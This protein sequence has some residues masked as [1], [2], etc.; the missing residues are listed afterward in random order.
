MNIVMMTNTYK[1][2]LGGL[3]RSVETVTAELR[4][5][6]HEVVIVMPEIEKG[7]PAP[8]PQVFR[9]P[10]L[11][12]VNHTDFPV[13]LP[14][15][16]ELAA[17]LK[18]FRPDI[19]HSH[20]PFLIGDTARIQLLHRRAG[21]GSRLLLQI[22]EI[23]PDQGDASFDLNKVERTAGHGTSRRCDPAP[24]ALDFTCSAARHPPPE[25]LR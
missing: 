21:K 23:P 20:H 8:E 24:L 1:P 12:H 3:E 17:V 18:K 6:G 9:V 7:M 13:Q 5:R 14:L 4:R 15:P 19:I 2:I 10:A 11:T 16:T 25:M 22:E